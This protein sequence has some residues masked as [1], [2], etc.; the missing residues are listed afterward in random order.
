MNLSRLFH[1]S[2][3]KVLA[4]FPFAAATLIEY[5]VRTALSRTFFNFLLCVFAVRLW[6]ISLIILSYTFV[7]V[8]RF[9]KLFFRISMYRS[10]NRAEKEG[11]EPSRRF[12][13]LHPFQ[14]CPFGQLGYFSELYIAQIS[15]PRMYLYRLLRTSLPHPSNAGQHRMFERREWDSNPRALS[16]KRFSRPPRYDHFDIS[17]LIFKIARGIERKNYY[18]YLPLLCQYKF[19]LFLF[20]SSGHSSFVRG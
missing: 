8:N 17:P 3:I 10:Y 11:F 15:L 1:C 14:G 9:F 7:L 5:H 16:D 19:Y 12:H 4:A 18:T 20:I 13:D 6:R 2:V